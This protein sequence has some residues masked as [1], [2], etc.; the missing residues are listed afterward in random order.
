M[1]SS[2]MN[3][4]MGNISID[5]EVIAQYAGSVANECF[6]I[7]GMAGV[8]MKEGIVNL[9]KK[10]TMTKGLDVTLTSANRLVIDFHVI[11]SY[12]VNITTVADNLI[13]S[14][15]YKVEEFTGSAGKVGTIAKVPFVRGVFL[16]PFSA[17]Q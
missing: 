17:G 4:H 10:D 6:G 9:L 11:V 5:N 15:R 14:I 12:G 3:T 8:N 1:K 7:V 16:F 2:Y 13:E